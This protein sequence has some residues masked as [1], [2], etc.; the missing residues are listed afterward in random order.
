[1]SKDKYYSFEQINIAQQ[2][3]PPDIFPL[4]SKMQVNSTVHA[5]G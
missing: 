3:V 5:L 4:R 1:L 2:I